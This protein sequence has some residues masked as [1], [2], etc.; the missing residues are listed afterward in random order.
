MPPTLIQHLQSDNSDGNLR[1]V[2]VSDPQTS[3]IQHL[4]SD[5]SDGNL[6][7]ATV[8]DTQTSVIKSNINN[9][10]APEKLNPTVYSNINA[11]FELKSNFR[12]VLLTLPTFNHNQKLFSYNEVSL[13]LSRYIL[14]KKDIF[15]DSRNVKLAI[16]RGDPLSKAF[17]VDSFHRCQ[18]TSLLR[19]KLSMY[20]MRFLG[21]LTVLNPPVE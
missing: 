14:S 16:I 13:L 15:F 4:Q 9:V 5:N 10:S 8:T 11:K 18:L 6:L 7:Q 2:T 17:Q 20:P 12:S 19:K 21:A 1:Q 3:V